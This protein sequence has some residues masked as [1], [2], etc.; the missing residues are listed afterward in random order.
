MLDTLSFDLW[1]DV[2]YRRHSVSF[3]EAFGFLWVNVW[4]CQSLV[5]LSLPRHPQGVRAMAVP[6][7]RV[8]EL[9]GKS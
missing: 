9:V 4:W 1:W 7:R 3:T 6:A 2:V 8:F 5:S